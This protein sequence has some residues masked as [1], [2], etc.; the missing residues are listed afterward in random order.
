MAKSGILI[1]AYD[2]ALETLIVIIP[3]PSLAPT[4]VLGKVWRS[5]PEMVPV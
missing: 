1:T 2:F 5:E 4:P 3:G